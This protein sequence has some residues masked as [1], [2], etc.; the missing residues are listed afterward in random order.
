MNRG[1]VNVLLILYVLF[2]LYN[3]LI[4]FDFQFKGNSLFAALESAEW[5]PFVYKGGRP[6]LTDIAGNILLFMPTGFLAY[7]WLC[8]RGFRAPI[9]L[10]AM[11]GLLL[12]FVIEFL[13]LFVK[14]RVSSTTDLILNGFG[15]FLGAFAAA[16]YFR[17]IAAHVNREIRRLIHEQPVTIFL[18][19]IF[20][21]QAVAAV[22]PF[23]ISI[24]ISDLIDSIKHTNIG[25]FQNTSLS[26]LLLHRPTEL[27]GTAF[28]WFPFLENLLFW[29]VWGYIV[30]V[31]YDSYWSIRRNANW[32]MIAVAFMPAILLEFSQIFIVSRYCDINDIIAN[33]LGVFSGLVLYSLLY[34]KHRLSSMEPWHKLIG[35][36]WLYF[37]FILFAGL[38]PFDFHF[39]DEAPSQ[40]ISPRALVPFYSYFSN[41]SLWNIYDLATSLIYFFPISLYLT[42]RLHQRHHPWTRIYFVTGISGL[43]LGIT[44][45]FFQFNTPTRVAEIT[46]ALSYGLGG[47]L[48]TFS[49]YYFI[50]EIRPTLEDQSWQAQ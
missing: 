35:A 43:L 41:T 21:L 10:A 15:T 34:R 42:Y 16:V 50:Q 12:S 33:W 36:V 29:S 24:T 45:E 30:S 28:S 40:A 23:R 32:L 19:A 2:T 27:D 48:G 13:Q 49:V 22:F 25:L 5:K 31:C 18:A 20:L 26:N 3:T 4:P 17:A 8:Q 7:L 39:F 47:F 6:P 14:G 9:I 37:I 38:Q 11:S 1:I 44:I 46:D